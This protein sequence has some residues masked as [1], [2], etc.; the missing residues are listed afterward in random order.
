[1]IEPGAISAADILAQMRALAAQA[2]GQAAPTPAG[3]GTA[4]FSALLKDSLDQ[5]NASQQNANRVGNAFELGDPNLS[6]A[7]VM[8]AVQKANLE[9]QAAT[10]V[11][12]KLV[13]AY[14]EIMSM[15]V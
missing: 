2:E 5:V 9:L 12:N 14:Q 13:A 11:R 6:V 10:Q 3:A 1:M 7:D 8:I 4:D 15:Q